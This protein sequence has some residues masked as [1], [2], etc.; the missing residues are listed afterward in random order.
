MSITETT[1]TWTAAMT[2]ALNTKILRLIPG[3]ALGSCLL[4]QEQVWVTKMPMADGTISFGTPKTVTHEI[5]TRM[6]TFQ[7]IL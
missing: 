1:D 2:E 4:K 5:I 6:V 7:G 3:K